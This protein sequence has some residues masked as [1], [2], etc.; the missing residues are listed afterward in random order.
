MRRDFLKKFTAGRIL[1]ALYLLVCIMAA[2]NIIPILEL[3]NQSIRKYNEIFS[4]STRKFE[5]MTE[6]RKN[7]NTIQSAQFKHVL[8]FSTVMMDEEEKKLKKALE[9]N[10]AIFSEYKTLVESEAEQ[11]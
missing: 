2:Y 3:T 4:R 9:E 1:I 11:R 8:A 10:N 7:F 6:L 5:L